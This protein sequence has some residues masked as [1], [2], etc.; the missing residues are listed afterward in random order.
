MKETI[1]FV[2]QVSGIKYE[3]LSDLAIEMA[4]KCLL[5]Y[6]GC[7]Y[8]GLDYESSIIVREYALE[9]YAPGNC[10]IIGSDR[11]L[12]PAG[13]CYT[14]GTSGHAAELDDCSNEG[15]GHPAVAIMPAALAMAEKKGG[16]WRERGT[17][18]NRQALRVPYRVLA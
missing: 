10:T 6:V 7:T 12:V 17:A 2:E 16:F 4:K 18:P 14:N 13:A 11:K 15:G 8:A 1:R 9:N 5:D 3:G